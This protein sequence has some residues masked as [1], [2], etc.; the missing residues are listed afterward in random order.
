MADLVIRF[1]HA[2]TACTSQIATATA[3]MAP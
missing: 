2:G 1:N 3:A